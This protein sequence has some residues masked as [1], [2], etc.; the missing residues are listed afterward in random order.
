MFT[1]FIMG[2]TCEYKYEPGNTKL[3][4]R[5]FKYTERIGLE[6]SFGK[7]QTKSSIKS[8]S[9]EDLVDSIKVS[10][11]TNS[12]TTNNELRDNKIKSIFFSNIMDGREI[13]GEFKN[14]RMKDEI[15]KI[16]LLIKMNQKEVI[17][18]L[19]MVIYKNKYVEMKGKF[20]LVQWNVS[21]SLELLVKECDLY[22]KGKD[23]IPKLSNDIE[24]YL[25]T[26]LQVNCKK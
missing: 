6:G 17:V 22:L 16:D 2:E 10:I 4:W 26:E 7:I 3:K 14:L 23:N 1:G 13:T 20:S 15:S 12:I 18:P 19:D 11:D 9:I 21:K 25:Y 5:A 8:N 24:I